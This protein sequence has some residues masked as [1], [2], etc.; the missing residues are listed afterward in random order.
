LAQ[1]DTT[2]PR[3]AKEYE[4]GQTVTGIDLDKLAVMRLFAR[5]SI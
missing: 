1:Y 5:L 4:A 3:S 2:E